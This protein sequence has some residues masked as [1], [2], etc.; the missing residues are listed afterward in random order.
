MEIQ[1]HSIEV[2]ARLELNRREL[3]LLNHIFSFDNLRTF[4]ESVASTSYGG[5]VTAKEAL[6]FMQN[7]RTKALEIMG[8]I[9]ENKK[10]LFRK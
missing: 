6:E 7:L 10:A 4:S 8:R 3:E 5:G 1:P 9:E 2:T